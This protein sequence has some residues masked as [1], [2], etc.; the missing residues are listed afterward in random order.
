MSSKARRVPLA[1]LKNGVNTAEDGIAVHQVSPAVFRSFA[2]LREILLYACLICFGVM[3]GMLKGPKGRLALLREENARFCAP[4]TRIPTPAP[5]KK[6]SQEAPS[7]G[8]FVSKIPS[9]TTISSTLEG[10][11]TS[12]NKDEDASSGIVK[13][14][15]QQQGSPHAQEPAFGNSDEDREAVTPEAQVQGHTE[16]EGITSEALQLSEDIATQLAC[17]P[18]AHAP[19]SPE[20]DASVS[21]QQASM[22][23]PQALAA[24]SPQ[25]AGMGTPLDFTSTLNL[26]EFD[27]STLA[28]AAAAEEATFGMQL[29]LPQTIILHLYIALSAL[30]ERQ[31]HC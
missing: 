24:S 30:T 2:H 1:H 14:K 8:N 22:S 15:R 18:A 6:P 23:S 19:M 31:G 5:K 25:V 28:V 26:E 17:T 4:K 16:L 29:P 21:G 27:G 9:P 20:E 12:Q 13:D 7:R 10:P 11:A 3:Q